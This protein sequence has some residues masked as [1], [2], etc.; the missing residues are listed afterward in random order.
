G[1]G[2][3]GFA[4]TGG[5]CAAAAAADRSGE[6]GGAGDPCR[7]EPPSGT[8][9]KGF[10]GNAGGA[11][12]AGATAGG[13]TAGGE[14]EGDPGAPGG[15]APGSGGAGGPK[16]II[17]AARCFTGAAR[18]VTTG[19]GI[20]AGAGGGGGGTVI[21]DGMLLGISN[22][23]PSVARVRPPPSSSHGFSSASDGRFG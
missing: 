10:A 2:G 12:T 21:G 9:G 13:G 8:A 16:P 20:G 22:D 17:V 3:A 7:V 23:G 6:D 4:A 15:G 1:V 11:G 19:T 14:G 5:G 18:G